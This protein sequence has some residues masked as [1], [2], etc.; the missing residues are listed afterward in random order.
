MKNVFFIG[1]V[2]FTLANFVNADN[3]TQQQSNE[4]AEQFE[5]QIL[6]HMLKQIYPESMDVMNKN[7]SNKIMRDFLLDEY[8]KILAK[9]NS[10][11]IAKNI[12]R[13]LSRKESQLISEKEKN[14]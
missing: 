1:L 13:D 9:K 2:F 3:F 5:A 14:E 4:V 11:G 10:I 7:A 12:K 6:A 8:G